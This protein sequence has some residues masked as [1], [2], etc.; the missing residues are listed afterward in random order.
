MAS[1][2][3]A[4]SV[5]S[6]LASCTAATNSCSKQIAMIDV[7]FIDKEKAGFS[8]FQFHGTGSAK[9]NFG[10]RTSRSVI[11]HPSA[12]YTSKRFVYLV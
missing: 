7:A 2:A 4:A 8:G 12:H 1:A 11:S 9:S 5:I 10:R 6:G 3:T